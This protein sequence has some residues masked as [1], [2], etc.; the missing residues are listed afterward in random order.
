MKP[1]SAGPIV[2]DESGRW[3]VRFHF[4]E[5]C[6]DQDNSPPRHA[7][8]LVGVPYGAGPSQGDAAHR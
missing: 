8:F 6:I 5:Q 3:V 2:L 4:Y 1:R 7:A